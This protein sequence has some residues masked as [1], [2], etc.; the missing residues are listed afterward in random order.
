MAKVALIKIFA[1]LNMSS[2][3]L[4]GELMRA[5]HEAH[6]YLYKEFLIRSPENRG[7]LDGGESMVMPNGQE[8]VWMLYHPFTDK[9]LKLL[10]DELRK[11]NPDAIGMSVPSLLIEMNAH[12]AGILRKEFP[13][14][15]IWGGTAPTLEPENCIAYTD[16]LCTNEGEEIIVEL[17]DR[18]DR[19][20]RLDNIPGTWFND[21]GNIIKNPKR[22]LVNLDNIA[23]PCWKRE[24]FTFI[25]EEQAKTPFLP[26]GI[27]A[28]YP[29]MTQRGCPFSCSFCIESRY[30]EMFGKKES[31]RRRSPE[32]V[33]EELRQAKATLGIRKVLFFD[34]VFTIN[35]RWLKE[36]LPRYKEEI[37]LPFWCYTYPTTH[38]LDLLKY[39]KEHGCVSVGMGIQTGSERLLKAHYNRP[40]EKQRIIKACQEIVEAGLEGVFDIIS[41]GP[42]DT[43]QDLRD[44]FELMLELPQELRCMG[45]GTMSLTPTI[46]LRRQT[47]EAGLIANNVYG[48]DTPLPDSLYDY[49]HKLFH[50]T[51]TNIDRDY[52]REIADDPR[53]KEDQ[54]F[55]Q[56]LIIEATEQR[57]FEGRSWKVT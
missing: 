40:T 25:D 43:E 8:M 57:D 34:D 37:G 30:Q 20:E 44:T 10:C 31:L 9:E 29:I 5:G 19:H 49:Y 46:S 53:H 13:V 32:L 23:I 45:Y 4:A 6:V 12:V 26:R 17:A 33:L 18:I 52:L 54:S 28:E 14:P 16:L 7:N 27:R 3:Q 47:E 15:M 22:P 38:T 55:L 1:G 48:Y 39:L 11:F 24:H 21:N 50:L 35:P 56:Q 36:F 51:R 41:K 42:F 2:A